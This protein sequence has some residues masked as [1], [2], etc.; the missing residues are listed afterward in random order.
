M[1]QTKILVDGFGFMGQTHAGNLLKNPQADLIGIIDPCN[2]VERLSSIK[3][4]KATVTITREEVLD[5]PHFHSLDEAIAKTRP[6]AVVI[7]LPTALHYSAVMQCLNAG[8]HVFV[9]KPFAVS[10]SECRKMVRT[11]QETRRLLAVGYVVRC[12]KEYEILK[13]TVASGRLGKL[14]LLKLN[15]MTGIPAWGDWKNPDFIKASGGSLF[16][17]VSH[18]IDFARFCLGE[19]E[20]IK[21]AN[22]SNCGQSS[23]I[24]AAFQYPEMDA[25]VEGGFVSP[26]TFPF[27][28]SFD[29]FFEKGTLSSH[30][31]GELSEITGQGIQVQNFSGD[32]PYYKETENFIRALQTGNIQGICTGEDAMKTIESC[33]LIAR[34]I[35]YPLPK[36]IEL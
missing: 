18:D 13:Q 5:L 32:N 21:F 23:V 36:E 17:L 30:T 8:I 19:P 22:W 7:A 35:N 14:N 9:E 15:R 34:R 20:E 27:Q 2:P 33:T 16:D 25:A 24:S 29:A 11:A 1:M 6:D 28:R 31:P 10:L 3:G 26:S 12:M 4:N